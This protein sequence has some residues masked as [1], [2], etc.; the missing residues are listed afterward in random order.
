[1]SNSN[2]CVHGILIHMVTQGEGNSTFELLGHDHEMHAV[3][4]LANLTKS[5]NR[6]D[7]FGE[8]GKFGKSS[9]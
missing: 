2:Q 6:F 4:N 7:D 9:S 1:M 8:F 3:R 5:C